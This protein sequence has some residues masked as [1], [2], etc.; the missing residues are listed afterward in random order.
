MRRSRAQVPGLHEIMTTFPTFETAS[1]SA[2]ALAPGPRRIEDDGVAAG[3]LARCQRGEEEIPGKCPHRLQLRR[4]PRRL[5]KCCDGRL[6]L[7]EG[8]KLA[9]GEGEGEGAA[10][11]EQICHASITRSSP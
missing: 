3:K 1:A 4:S 7:F 6:I 10:A 8:I 9:S 11:C 5:A 2:C